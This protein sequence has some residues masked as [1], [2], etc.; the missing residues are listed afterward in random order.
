MEGKHGPKMPNLVDDVESEVESGATELSL[1]FSSTKSYPLHDH[2]EQK[3]HSSGAAP[4]N[5][6]H[7]L[8][9]AHSRSN[10]FI[11]HTSKLVSISCISDIGVSTCW[12]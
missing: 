5:T 3:Y 9:L 2:L 10:S 4:N 8:I 7:L 6:L 1:T 11:I 12:N